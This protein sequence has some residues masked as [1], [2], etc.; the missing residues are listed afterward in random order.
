MT[1][2][3]TGESVVHVVLLTQQPSVPVLI[4]RFRRGG[5]D[6][7]LGEGKDED[8]YCRSLKMFLCTFLWVAVRAPVCNTSCLL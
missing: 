1:Q 8:L 7:L 6:C 4:T 5:P 3:S 2:L